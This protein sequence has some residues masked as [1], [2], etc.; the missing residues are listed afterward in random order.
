MQL[1]YIK[2]CYKREFPQPVFDAY[3]KERTCNNETDERYNGYR[4]VLDV[5]K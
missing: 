5:V 2:K 3:C 1:Y 4:V